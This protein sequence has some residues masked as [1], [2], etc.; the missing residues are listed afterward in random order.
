M[1]CLNSVLPSTD[2]IFKSFVISFKICDKQDV[3]T[4]STSG[5]GHSIFC[6]SGLDFYGDQQIFVHLHLG[7]SIHDCE[8]SNAICAGRLIST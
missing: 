3:K 5:K 7:A 6:Q 8:D 1:T 2:T 4:G